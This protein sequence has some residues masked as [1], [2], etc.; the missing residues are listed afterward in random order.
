MAVSDSNSAQS[1]PN[2]KICMLVFAAFGVH[3]FIWSIVSVI[4]F[5][6]N[7]I[8]SVLMKIGWSLMCESVKLSVCSIPDKLVMHVLKILPFGLGSLYIP[9]FL[10]PVLVSQETNF[11]NVC[12]SWLMV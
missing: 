7:V 12:F 8:S 6:V 2:G 9:W 4:L 3:G 11:R 10:F 1:K 5:V